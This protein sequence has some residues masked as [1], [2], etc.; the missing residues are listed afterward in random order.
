M[1]LG[2]GC[3]DIVAQTFAVA[4]RRRDELPAEA[5]RLWLFGTAR[6]LLANSARVGPAS[7][8]GEAP[9]RWR[10]RAVN[11]RGRCRD[12]RPSA[13]LEALIGRLDPGAGE[14]V[15]AIGSERFE[16]IQ[17]R[18]IGGDSNR[19][20]PSRRV[21]VPAAS[22]AIVIA[23]VGG[24][25]AVNAGDKPEVDVAVREATSNLNEIVSLEVDI[26]QRYGDNVG[27]S[28]IRINGDD[29][30]DFSAGYYED[31]HVEVARRWL[32]D[33][34]LFETIEGVTTAIEEDPA[35]A[36]SGYAQSSASVIGAVLDVVEPDRAG[37]EVINGL[38]ATRYDLTLS[39]DAVSASEAL[40]A[41]QVAFFDLEDPSDIR[42]ISVWVAGE[43]IHQI[44]VERKEGT[45]TSTFSHFNARLTITAPPGPYERSVD[46]Q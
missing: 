24:F 46:D 7:G 25:V 5:A 40:P 30:E 3:D 16:W 18:A 10:A 11:G 33:G 28:H 23:G 14:D 41:R 36:P 19:R 31:G 34:T 17:T 43:L 37:V 42:R 32:V 29:I 13:E 2:C 9:A 26:Y 35:W 45:R 21:W 4:W 39:D 38:L 44:E 20:G 12:R 8:E 15:P 6:N 22:A 27:W 1:R